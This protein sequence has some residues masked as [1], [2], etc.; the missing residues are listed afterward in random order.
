MPAGEIDES[1]E[2]EDMETPLDEG[3]LDG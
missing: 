3:V 2:S 1:L